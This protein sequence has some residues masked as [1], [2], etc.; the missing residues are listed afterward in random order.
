MRNS[1]HILVTGG[2][3]KTGRRVVEQLKARQIEVRV[4]SRKGEPPF[5]WNEQST[6]AAAL[7]GIDA[8]YITYQP[9]LAV[10]G[11]LETIK[12]FSQ[13]AVEA[14]V[15]QLVLLSGRGEPE[16]QAG[17]QRPHDLLQPL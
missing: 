4:G 3:G 15:T 6:W 16:A 2:T 7:H 10:P 17:D 14:G 12:A 8:V 5:D 1:K 9:D 11:A 13:Q